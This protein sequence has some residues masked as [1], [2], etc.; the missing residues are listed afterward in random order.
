[1]RLRL[2][3]PNSKA[4]YIKT[5]ILVLVVDSLYVRHLSAARTAPRRPEVNKD[6][7]AVSNIVRELN[8]LLERLRIYT[9]VITINVLYCEVCKLHT[10]CSSLSCIKTL[11]EIS[12]LLIL[13]HS[14]RHL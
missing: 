3:L 1:M 2:S 5:L 8:F 14:L 13:E 11:L 6:I 12:Y 9:S 7:F 10:L 4:D